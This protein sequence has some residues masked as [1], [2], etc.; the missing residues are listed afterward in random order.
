M[1]LKAVANTNFFFCSH[2]H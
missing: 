2:E 1:H